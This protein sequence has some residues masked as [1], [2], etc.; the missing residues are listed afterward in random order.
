MQDWGLPLSMLLPRIY[1]KSDQRKQ[2][3]LFLL[4]KTDALQG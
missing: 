3:D 2:S 1:Q 4:S